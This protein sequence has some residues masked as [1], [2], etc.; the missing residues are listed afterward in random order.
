ML[1]RVTLPTNF[2]GKESCLREMR[3][4]YCFSPATH[5]DQSETN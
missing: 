3:H 5:A 1:K 4:W 2:F